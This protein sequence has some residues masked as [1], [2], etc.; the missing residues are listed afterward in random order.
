M[1][2]DYKM[3]C[4]AC[5]NETKYI[6][7][8]LN[9]SKCK[10]NVHIDDFKNELKAYKESYTK[11]KRRQNMDM[12]RTTAGDQIKESQNKWKK[13]SRERQ[14]KNDET[15]VKLQQN[16]RKKASRANQR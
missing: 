11:L 12:K 16:D 1:S 14:R 15:K 9:K 2:H 7:Q 10:K 4:P 5:G 6:I 13:Q 8:H 3:R